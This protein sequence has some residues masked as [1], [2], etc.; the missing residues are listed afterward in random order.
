V[1]DSTMEACMLKDWGTRRECVEDDDTFGSLCFG[2]REDIT[3]GVS[4]WAETREDQSTIF[5]LASGVTL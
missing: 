3:L 2:G 5:C 4:D 1:D